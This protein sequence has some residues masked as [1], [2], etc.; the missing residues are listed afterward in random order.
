MS[1]KLMKLLSLC[2]LSLTIVSAGIAQKHGSPSHSQEA[3]SKARLERI[4]TDA[5]SS[6]PRLQVLVAQTGPSKAGDLVSSNN[7]VVQMIYAAHM[8]QA[9]GPDS[10]TD[11]LNALPRSATEMEAFYEFTH[12]KGAEQFLPYYSAFYKD[13]FQLVVHQPNA[14]PKLFDVATQFDTKLWPNYEDVDF[15]CSRLGELRAKIPAQYDR[16][17]KSRNLKDRKF[18]TDCGR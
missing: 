1:T 2:L 12:E 8:Y 3:S 17:M 16:A 13:A 18:L 6:R 14:L 7:P 15:F 9:S 10:S 11:V 4:L 5:K